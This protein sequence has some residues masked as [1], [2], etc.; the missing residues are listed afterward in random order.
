MRTFEELGFAILANILDERS[1]SELCDDIT[2]LDGDEQ[3]GVRNRRPYGIR[4]FINRSPAVRRLAGGDTALEIVDRF[5]GKG[6]KVVR[7]I[8]FDKTQEANWKVPWHQDLTIAVKKRAAIPGFAPW[9]QKGGVWHVQ[10]P[11]GILENMITLR[12]HLDDADENNGALKII[13]DSHR[14]GRLNAEQIK[15][16]RAANESRVCR[17]KKGD[18]LVMSPLLLHSSSAGTNPKRRR[19]VHLEYSVAALPDGL[20]WHGS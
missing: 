12:F 3:V 17:V 9:T 11:T 16:I 13:P 6:A 18:C 20:D 7:A 19:V 8:Y 14:R 4:D 2:A 5:L 1:I 15:E 10:P